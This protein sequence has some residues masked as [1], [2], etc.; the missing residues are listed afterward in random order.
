MK[1]T[2]IASL[3]TFILI[4]SFASIAFAG[5]NYSIPVS[6]TIPAIP[7][8]NAPLIQEETAVNNVSTSMDKDQTKTLIQQDSPGEKASTILQ[9]LYDR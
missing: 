3:G 4:F 6:V 9:T 5:N 8:V 7:G 2:L 1:K